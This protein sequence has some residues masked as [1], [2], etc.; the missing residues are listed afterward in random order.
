M[1]ERARFR[2]AKAPLLPHRSAHRCGG[3]P[4]C[5][6]AKCHELHT[7]SFLDLGRLTLSSPNLEFL[8]AFDVRPGDPVI[9]VRRSTYR[10]RTCAAVLQFD[11]ARTRR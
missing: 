7:Q 2:S 4:D 3:A 8:G 11:S 1:P 5:T 10:C 6:I 9:E